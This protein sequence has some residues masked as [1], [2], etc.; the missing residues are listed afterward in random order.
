MTQVLPALAAMLAVQI[1]ASMAVAA[2]P[3]LAPL[4]AADFGVEAHHI[5]TYISLAYVL[6][7]SVGLVSGGLIARFGAFRIAQSCLCL[8]GAGLL[9][10]ALAMPAAALVAAVVIGCGSGPTTPSSSQILARLT[11]PKW[12]NA[13]F[14]ARQMGVPLGGALAGLMMPALAVMFGWR[15]AVAVGA[16][17]CLA[18]AL[19]LEPW[20]RQ[21]DSG[22]DRDRRFFSLTQLSNPL[23]IVFGTAE[24]RRMMIVGFV[25]AGIQ[26]TF[27]TFLITYLH[28]RLGMT[29]VQ[30][31]FVLTAALTTGAIGRI[32][33]GTIADRFVAPRLMLGGLGLGM[34]VCSLATAGFAP[35]WPFALIVA[36]CMAFG[37]TTIAWNGVFLAQIA[38]LA[39]PGGV[40]DTTGG[41]TFC[42]FAGVVALPG[43]FTLLLAL[44]GSYALGFTVAAAL[45]L[46]GGVWMLRPADSAAARTNP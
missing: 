39:P 8:A 31:G 38:H 12:M 4:A 13:V 28:D 21:L 40:A 35:D 7:A 2:G 43:M 37:A 20:R 18:L 45:T 44:T 25:Y 6:A 16:A 10:G 29:L 1:F 33:W 17:L 14:S 46:A 3:V 11:P 41:A 23:R 34:S 22:R 15:A 32:V 19:G 5:G 30:A 27:S 36:V 9:I 42:L 26:T 24:L